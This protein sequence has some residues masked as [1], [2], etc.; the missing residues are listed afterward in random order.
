MATVLITGGSR[1]IG[2][3]TAERFLVDGHTVHIAARHPDAAMETER[4]R[5][6]TFDLTNPDGIPKFLGQIGRIDVLVNNAGVMHSLPFDAYPEDK[7]QSM[8]Q[9]N[10]EAPVALITHMAPLMRQQG[11][12]RIVNV[13]SIA[14]HIGHPDIW[15]GITKAGILNAT[16]SFAKLFAKDN[17]MVTA[18]APGPVETDMM[19]QIPPER[20]NDLRA[21][22]Y[23]G[24]FAVPQ[25]IAEIIFWL[26]TAAPMQLNGTCIDANNGAFPR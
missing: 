2:K 1:G 15:Y 24:H 19:Q 11:G 12:G 4:C 17:I 7:K 14:G 6:H 21:R 25:D 20:L 22:T 5:L 23:D 26:A 3:A 16:K 18:V 13:A 10:L 8:L 9:I